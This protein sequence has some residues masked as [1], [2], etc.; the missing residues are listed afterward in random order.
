MPRQKEYCE[1]EVI[2]KAMDLFWRNGYESTTVRMLEKE[3]GINQFSIYSSFGSKD[4]LYLESIKCYINKIKNI[5]DKL[6]EA[7]RGIEDIK[8]FFYD[9]LEFSIESKVRKGCFL[10]NTANELGEDPDSIIMSEIAKYKASLK[11]IYIEKLEINS[12]KDKLTIEREA[13]YL[14]IAKQGLSVASKIFKKKEL[15]DFIELTFSKL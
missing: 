10:T 5:V 8:Q 2:V 3:M 9:F 13:N 15:E 4:G 7:S 6:K 12:N 11:A 1:E 14:M